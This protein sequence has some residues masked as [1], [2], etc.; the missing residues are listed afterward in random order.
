MSKY[1][2]RGDYDHVSDYNHM[3]RT[4]QRSSI[5]LS[6]SRCHLMRKMRMRMKSQKKKGS[7][8]TKSGIKGETRNS[9]SSMKRSQGTSFGKVM[10][11]LITRSRVRVK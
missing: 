2:H 11:P 1:I 5:L 6:L 7:S 3:L 9:T 4:Q 8:I 10:E